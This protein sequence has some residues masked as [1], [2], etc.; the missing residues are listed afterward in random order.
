LQA[1]EVAFLA[2]FSTAIIPI[3]FPMRQAH[4]TPE[5]A[6]RPGVALSKDKLR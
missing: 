2:I 4:V 1:A 5:A 6:A 3:D